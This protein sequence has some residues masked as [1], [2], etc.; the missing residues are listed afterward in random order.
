MDPDIRQWHALQAW[1]EAGP[2]EV[3]VP[4]AGA[5]AAMIPPVAVRLRRDF[6]AVLTLIRSHALLHQ[7]SRERDAAGRIV[8]T[9]DD[10][11]V[12]RDLITDIVAEGL[13]VSVPAT[14]RET[15]ELV[16]D[17]LRDE[18]KGTAVT[19]ADIGRNLR[20]DRS[21][22]ARRVQAAEHRGFLKN[23]EDKRGKPGRFVIGDPLPADRVILPAVEDLSGE[24]CVGVHDKPEGDSTP[25][26]PPNG[27]RSGTEGDDTPA[28][29]PAQAHTPEI[30]QVLT[31]AERLNFLEVAIGDETV[32]PG[33]D[34]WHAWVTGKRNGQVAAAHR[35][36][37]KIAVVHGV[38]P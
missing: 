20:I 27:D 26:P 16:R 33:A 3:T 7:A 17:M 31:L 13:E 21:A 23:L 30:E 8:A 25:S 36:L 4:Y 29:T 1:I 19:V 2:C 11:A 6:K 22:A 32:G 28:D 24:G 18:N 14:V 10:Y 9:L 34:A 5:L 38:M 35:L 37:R 15:V 12:V